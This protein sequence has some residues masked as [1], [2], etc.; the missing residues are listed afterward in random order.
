MENNLRTVIGSSVPMTVLSK[1]GE[2]FTLLFKKCNLYYYDLIS[3]NIGEEKFNAIFNS[4]SAKSISDCALVL[5][6][7]IDPRSIKELIFLT[8]DEFL[9]YDNET[10]TV[11][12]SDP[13]VEDRIKFIF[14]NNFESLLALLL[15]L[16]QDDKENKKKK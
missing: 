3:L 5:S 11:K 14:G 6:F 13:S 4:P 2:E 15:E 1:D 8:E 10:G 12:K 16:F 7:L 9:K